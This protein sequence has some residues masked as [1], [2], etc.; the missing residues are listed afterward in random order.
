[1]LFDVSNIRMKPPFPSAQQSYNYNS[2]SVGIYSHV[3]TRRRHFKKIS[4]AVVLTA[5]IRRIN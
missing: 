1:M 4:T 3:N 2:T 5:T